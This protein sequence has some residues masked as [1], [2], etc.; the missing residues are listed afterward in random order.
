MR[1]S[2]LF[3]A[4][5]VNIKHPHTFRTYRCGELDL[6]PT[7]VDAVCAS[8]AVPTIFSPVKIGTQSFVGGALGA[9]NPTQVLLKEAIDIFDKKDERKTRIAQIISLGSGA[10]P[11]MTAATMTDPQGVGQVMQ[12]MTADS[13][14]LARELSVRL[15]SNDAYIRFSVDR[16]MENVSLDDWSGLGE[17]SNHTDEYVQRPG[18]T[19]DIDACL[20]RIRER[21]GTTTL[22]QIS[23]C[24]AK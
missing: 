21:I 4:T 11:I 6:S 17:I 15:F 2:A 22:W 9:S 3:A 18:V 7:I 13:E 23:E 24:I 5:P 16:G 20:K 14:V 10:P 1:P 19:K 12:V 8:M